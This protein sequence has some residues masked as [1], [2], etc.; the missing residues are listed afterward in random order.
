ARPTEG[1]L[2]GR[3]VRLLEP[4][5]YM[6]RSGDALAPYVHRPFWSVRND[7]LVVVDDVA[8][9]LGTWRYRTKGSAGGHNGL[10]SIEQALGTQEYARLRVGVGPGEVVPGA[11]LRDFV[12]GEFGA[13]ET[14]VVRAQLPALVAAVAEW[15]ARGT[16]NP[17]PA[18]ERKP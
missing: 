1:S 7:L 6:N 17:P 4:R 8:L 12:L 14:A 9:P 13:E 16:I 11:V 2:D 18:D 15:V 10:R 5:T 3:K